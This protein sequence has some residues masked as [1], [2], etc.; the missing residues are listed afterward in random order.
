MIPAGENPASRLQRFGRTRRRRG[1]LAALAAGVA[2]A[3]LPANAD[4]GARGAI[5]ASPIAPLPDAAAPSQQRA[6]AVDGWS[7]RSAPEVTA[8]DAAGAA[9]AATVPLAAN[10][11]IGETA[12]A[13][14]SAAPPA[15]AVD[16][17]ATF[18]RALGAIEA[19]KA[20]EG[21]RLLEQL[22]ARSPASTLANEARRRLAEIYARVFAP[23]AATAPASAAPA[24]AVAVAAPPARDMAAAADRAADKPAAWRDRARRTHRFEG[25]LGAE[26]GDRVF[27]GLSSSDIGARARAVLE[28]QAR[29][30]AR[31]PDLY[32]VVE[33][34]ADEP[35][36]AAQNRAVSLERADKARRLL[37]AGGLSPERI[38]VDPRGSQD[39]VASCDSSQCQAQNRRVVTRLMVVLPAGRD[40][41]SA[42]E[43]LPPGAPRLATDG[44]AGR[45]TAR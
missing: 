19:G 4:S 28:R 13:P 43:D 35:G 5:E 7:S 22:V 8:S 10:S 41:S 25:M 31:Y 36:D 32:V 39:R 34:H 30:I 6:T 44:V 18:E 12:P 14:V 9:A 2:L 17:H 40:R 26:V 42:G 38:D 3:S 29:W 21:Q 37:I 20:D 24:A 11:R 33:G 16:D 1:V 23:P 15:E 27:F 45:P